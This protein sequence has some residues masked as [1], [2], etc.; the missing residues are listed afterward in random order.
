MQHS[1]DKAKWVELFQALGLDEATMMRWHE[2]FE[3]RYPE[4]HEAFLEWLRIPPQEIAAIRAHSR[5]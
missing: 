3:A 4:G 5:S 1:M 2:L